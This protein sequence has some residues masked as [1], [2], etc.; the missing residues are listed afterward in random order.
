MRG[1][2]HEL[3]IAYLHGRL[4]VQIESAANSIGIPF[5]E[6]A[7]RLGSLLLTSSGRQV[8]GAPDNMP[9]LRGETTGDRTTVAKVAVARRPYRR[10]QKVKK[11]NWWFKRTPEQQKAIT[12]KRVKSMKERREKK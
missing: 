4:E 11:L 2:N 9:T 1:N 10:T 7:G 6:L 8:L 3:Q 12:A 5:H